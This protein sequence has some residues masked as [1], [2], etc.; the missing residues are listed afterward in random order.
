MLGNCLKYNAKNTKFMQNSQKCENKLARVIYP[1]LSYKI[2]G[3]VFSARRKLGIYCNE[4]QYCDF[5]ETCFK[6]EGVLYEREKAM[7]SSFE[8]EQPF[9]NKVDFLIENKIVFEAKAKRFLTKDDYYQM[10]RYLSAVNK[11]LG[12][13]VNFRQK[14]VQPKR[15]I[16]SAAK[17][18]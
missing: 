16:N 10:R 18:E 6:K 12:I 4:K 15:I 7:P 2:N 14:Q 13:L 5:M 11:K 9:R 1:E 17:E 3:M 8:G